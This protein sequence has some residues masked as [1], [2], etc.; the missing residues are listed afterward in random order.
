MVFRFE[1]S[2]GTPLNHEKIQHLRDAGYFP[3][4]NFSIWT[5]LSVF[6]FFPI[7]GILFW[8]GL[9]QLRLTPGGTKY[10]EMHLV[11]EYYANLFVRAVRTRSGD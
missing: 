7:L 3:A 11:V 4:L 9:A 2:H 1:R 6:C 10:V 5:R 8:L